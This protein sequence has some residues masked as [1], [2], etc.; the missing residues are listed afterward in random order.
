MR[1]YP[2]ITGLSRKQKM[3]C[4]IMW[5]IETREKLEQFIFSLGEKDQLECMMLIEMMQLAIIDEVSFTD[6]A[7][8]VLS[9]YLAK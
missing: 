7:D 1:T 5:N 9:K 2:K 8:E 4:D 6:D 3:F